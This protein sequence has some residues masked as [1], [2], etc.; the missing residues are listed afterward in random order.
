MA[1]ST[2]KLY[3][4][5]AHK[6]IERITSLPAVAVRTTSLDQSLS[7]QYC[8]SFSRPKWTKKTMKIL[9]VSF[10]LR[11]YFSVILKPTARSGA[12]LKTTANAR[13]ISLLLWL[14]TYSVTYLFLHATTATAWGR[15]PWD[16]EARA[17]LISNNI[18]SAHCR[19]ALSR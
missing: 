10:L 19:C 11:H 9:S 14:I 12:A 13:L 3:A 5:L 1:Y 4:A 15:Q 17:P 7:V 2:T 18:L 6:D 16:T 8:D